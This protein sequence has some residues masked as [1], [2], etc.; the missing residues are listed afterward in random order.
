MSLIGPSSK[1]RSRPR[2]STASPISLKKKTPYLQHNNR[3]PPYN[4]HAY[5]HLLAAGFLLDRIVEDYVEEDL[6]FVRVGS[7]RVLFK[8][9]LVICVG[10]FCDCD[11]M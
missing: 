10:S 2:P 8:F 7:A 1:E 11:V 4:H 9:H 6:Q 3:I 5:R